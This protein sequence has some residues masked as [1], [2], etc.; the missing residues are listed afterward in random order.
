M[1]KAILVTVMMAAVVALAACSSNVPI[2]TPS[3]SSVVGAWQ[4]GADVLRLNA[5]GTFSLNAIPL[6]VVEQR[7][8]ALGGHPAG[9]NESVSGRWSIGSGGTDAGGAPGVHLEF[10]HP[11][12]VG[13][14]YGLTL[15]V[16]SDVPVQL[17]VLLGPPDSGT[18]YSFRKR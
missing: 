10:A 15:V 17:Y 13:F 14:D 9:P 4:H 6:G 5:D 1:R 16:S 7:A 11:R 8:V 3:P 18:R 12:K 2:S